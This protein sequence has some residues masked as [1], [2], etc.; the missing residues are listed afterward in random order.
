MSAPVGALPLFPQSLFDFVHANVRIWRLMA[1]LRHS[2]MCPVRFQWRRCPGRSNG[3]LELC[4]L[5][6]LLLQSDAQSSDFRVSFKL[7]FGEQSRPLLLLHQFLSC[8]H[9]KQRR[10]TCR[11]GIADAGR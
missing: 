3:I 9:Q 4:Q 6:L 5:V 11:R 7:R 2:A 10:R 8:G 1:S